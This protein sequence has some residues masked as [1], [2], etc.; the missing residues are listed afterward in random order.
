LIQTYKRYQ[1]QYAKN[2]EMM[3]KVLAETVDNIKGQLYKG[4]LAIGTGSY[5]VHTISSIFKESQG[6]VT[7]AAK[8]VT[9]SV[10][11][12]AIQ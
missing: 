7:D 11:N 3:Q 2:P 9:Q 4:N 10:F 6:A 8:N 1:K 5:Q 12:L